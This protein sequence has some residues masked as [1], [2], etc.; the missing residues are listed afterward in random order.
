MP[1]IEVV[2][3]VVNRKSL[4]LSYFTDETEEAKA[5]DRAARKYHGQFAVLNFK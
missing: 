3:I 2:K 5:Y 4:H 1:K